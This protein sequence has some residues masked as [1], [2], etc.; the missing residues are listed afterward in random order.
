MRREKI[1]KLESDLCA[2]FL[3]ALP[4]EWTAYPE[5][6]GWD[7]LLVRKKDGAQIGIEA[8]LKLNA[9]VLTQAIERSAWSADSRGPDFRAV[10][11]PSYEVTMRSVAAYIGIVVIGVRKMGMRSYFDP[12]LPG[13]AHAQDWPDQFPTQR[14][15]L[16]EYVPDAVAGTPSPLTLTPWKIAAMRLCILL[17]R[18]G[19]VVRTDFKHLHLDHRRWIAAGS[20]WLEPDNINKCWRRGFRCPDLKSQHPRNWEEIAADFERWAPPEPLRPAV[21]ADLLS[22]APC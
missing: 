6:C 1:F 13:D 14:H 17:E 12:F 15:Q 4:P 11:V 8:K 22:S 18:R 3:S 10:L 19:Y 16:P 9:A 5:S 21:T 2:A 20:G 7:I